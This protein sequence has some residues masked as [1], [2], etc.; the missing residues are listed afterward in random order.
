MTTPF[1]DLPELGQQ[2]GQ[3][4][5][6]FKAVLNFYDTN[7]RVLVQEV[8]SR[9]RR[10]ED[11]PGYHARAAIKAAE[12]LESAIEN[13]GNLQI[14]L[15]TNAG[16]VGMAATSIVDSLQLKYL[17]SFGKVSLKIPPGQDPGKV[18]Q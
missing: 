15:M 11:P 17:S 14:T 16:F 12:E 9:L 8:V 5:N 13:F 3:S 1:D 2:L 18:I 6:D 10:L 7:G 4:I